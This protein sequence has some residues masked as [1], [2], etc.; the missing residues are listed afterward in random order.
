MARPIVG[1]L[2]SMMCPEPKCAAG[3][4]SRGAKASRECSLACKF[5]QLRSAPRKRSRCSAD[6]DHATKR[7]NSSG[8]TLP[9]DRTATAIF[10]AHV[11][12]SRQ[13]RRERD[14]LVNR[15]GYFGD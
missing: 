14:F 8:S 3:A 1:G 7:W 15:D 9:P 10:T 6:R 5:H 11:D 2:Y 13:Q 4:W 12:L